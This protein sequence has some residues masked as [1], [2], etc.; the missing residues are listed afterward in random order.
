MSE[1]SLAERPAVAQAFAEPVRDICMGAR[2][3]VR[4]LELE[5]GG[6]F[7]L[8]SV[9]EHG[10]ETRNFHIPAQHAAELAKILGV[11]AGDVAGASSSSPPGGRRQGVNYDPT[12]H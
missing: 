7:L 6:R 11:A 10:K 12:A 9:L 5:D 2:F 4:N 1:K 8:L 3:A